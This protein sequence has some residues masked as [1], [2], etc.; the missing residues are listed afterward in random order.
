MDILSLIFYNLKH[1]HLIFLEVLLGKEDF[2]GNLERIG[3]VNKCMKEF[4]F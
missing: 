3:K 4:I 1:D 2:L